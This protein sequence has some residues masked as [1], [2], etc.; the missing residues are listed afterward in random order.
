MICNDEHVFV[1]PLSAR[2]KPLT[3]TG[4][5]FCWI[6]KDLRLYNFLTSFYFGLQIRI[7]LILYRMHNFNQNQ[8]MW[9]YVYNCFTMFSPC[10]QHFWPPQVRR[11]PWKACGSAATPRRRKQCQRRRAR[12]DVPS[13]GNKV[14]KCPR[15][16]LGEMGNW[17]TFDTRKTLG[18]HLENDFFGG[19]L[20][21][22][23]YFM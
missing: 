21:N 4:P 11:S 13:R 6:L 9:C 20:S 3:G 22:L 10:F 12:I 8:G 7:Y 15:G 2:L 23:G 1:S 18:F 5:A 17:W 16:A 19:I 14:R